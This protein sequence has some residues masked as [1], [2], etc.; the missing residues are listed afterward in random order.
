[1]STPDTFH[2]PVRLYLAALDDLERVIASLANAHTVRTE[3]LRPVEGV[4][5]EVPGAP[6]LPPQG[7]FSTQTLWRPRDPLALS[8]LTDLYEVVGRFSFQGD[9]DTNL[10]NL[11]TLVTSLRSELE[12]QRAS[13]KDLARVSSM[14]SEYAGSLEERD[15]A[16]S[17]AQQTEA[18][19]QFEP[20]ALQLK[21]I[22]QKLL[23]AIRAEKRPDLSKLDSSDTN[24]Q[25]YVNRVRVL[26][27][28]AL[29]FLRAQLVELCRLAE[30]DVPP[31]WPD[32]LPFAAT[33]PPEFVT[34]PSPDTPALVQAR[35]SSEQWAAQEAH[36]Q[37]AQDELGV[38]LR[39]A[40][41]ELTAL[42]Q[43]E[44]EALKE[45]AIG[46]ILV[47]QATQLDT[48]DALRAHLTAIQSD[49]TSR[50][51]S[52]TSYNAEIV[53]IH[54]TIQTLQKDATEGA[55]AIEAREEAI[56]AHR[57]D[58][59]ALFGKDDWRK[60]LEDLE[61]SLSE[62]RTDLLKQQHSIVASQ[63]EV[64]RL[65]SRVATEQQAIAALARTL[66]ETRA[67][68]TSTQ[69]ELTRIDQELGAQ[70]PARRLTVAQA[71]ETLVAIQAARNE[72]RSRVE[73][74]GAEMRRIRED[75][76]RAAVQIKQLS[77]ERE[78]HQSTLQTAHKQSTTLHDE[79]LRTLASR[80]Q[81]AFE[82]HAQQV[83][84]G[85]EDSLAQVERVFVEPA[86]RAVLVRAGVMSGAPEHIRERARVF[87]TTAAE[88]ASHA[89]AVY[90]AQAAT[91]DT[92]ERE[93][94]SKATTL[95]STAWTS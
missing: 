15:L 9:D 7:V 16:T 25:D 63:S 91:L 51:Q 33:L 53:R 2:T 40:D 88:A 41:G 81:A 28:K 12:R 59:P 86:R 34:A 21:D 66:D 83:L 57:K 93:F 20:V 77:A 55:Q 92:L 74:T 18:L 90:L 78:R 54:T 43:R 71:E 14:A 76:D 85:L 61:N 56:K 50:T 31:S 68:E 80:R 1:M 44:A 37:R 8:G 87:G 38:Q 65:Q 48:L 46:K 62:M 94:L 45:I 13:W 52:I 82:S 49:G 10:K 84:S 75:L 73:R 95:C 72:A 24:Y 3:T 22:A 26:Y 70:R 4:L 89:E 60:K 29:P 42:A 23:G 64:S 32:V 67:R 35:Q 69:Q 27:N 36:L 47:R 11:A 5:K 58:E 6:M 19:K 39:R 79:A 17:R 30:C